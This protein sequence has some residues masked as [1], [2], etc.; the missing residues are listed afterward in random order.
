MEVAT[1]TIFHS[2]VPRAMLGRVFG[3]LYGAIRMA[4]G[5][6][7]AVGGLP[8]EVSS[9]RLTFVLAGSGRLLA[10]LAAA[11]ALRRVPR[12]PNR[13]ATGLTERGYPGART[14]RLAD[15]P[16]SNDAPG[17]DDPGARRGRRTTTT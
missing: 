11:L 3:N 17:G 9:P 6:S 14:A 5:L 8:S 7:Y 2:A 4:A 15:D 13:R 10:T 12:M 16:Q 1:D